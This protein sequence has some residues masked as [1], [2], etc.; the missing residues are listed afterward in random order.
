MT[1]N[2][3]SH[4]RHFIA[5]ALIA[6]AAIVGIFTAIGLAFYYYVP[7]PAAPAGVAYYPYFPFGGF[8]VLFWIFIGFMALRWI[9]WPWR[10]GLGGGWHYRNRYWRYRDESY[11]ITRERYAKGEI[12]KDQYDR[13]MRDLDQHGQ[14]A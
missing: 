1:E 6:L 7:R 3:R 4:P 5:L 12:T 10:W 11:Y 14:T 2:Q 9:F 13:M 8:F